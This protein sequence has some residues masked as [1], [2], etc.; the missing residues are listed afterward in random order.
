M[1]NRFSSEHFPKEDEDP[2]GALANLVDIILVFACGLIAALVALS[3]NLQEHFKVEGV[4]GFGLDELPFASYAA[5]ALLRYVKHTQSQN[6]LHIQSIQVEQ[7]GEF[8]MA[9][10]PEKVF[11]LKG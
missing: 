5:G 4:A 7:L 11:L 10:E 8:V 1:K 3:P 9:P 6:L 2:L